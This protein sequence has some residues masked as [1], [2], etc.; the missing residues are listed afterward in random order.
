MVAENVA[1]AA[2][3]RRGNRGAFTHFSSLASARDS[4]DPSHV[5]F[6]PV[7]EEAVRYWRELRGPATTPARAAIAVALGLAW[8]LALGAPPLAAFCVA[9]VPLVCIVCI[10]FRLDGA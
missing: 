9:A 4:D 5:A 3:A 2:A 10:W 6:S 8:G 1:R 7:R